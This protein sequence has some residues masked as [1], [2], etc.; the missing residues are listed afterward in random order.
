[1]YFYHLHHAA[2]YSFLHA[3][4]FVETILDFKYKNM[5]VKTTKEE[6]DQDLHCQYKEAYPSTNI[7]HGKWHVLIENVLWTNA[8]DI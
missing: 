3:T 4:H 2:A 1:M 6:A 8:V 7:E 5:N